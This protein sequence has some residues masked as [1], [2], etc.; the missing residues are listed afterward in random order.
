MRQVSIGQLDVS[1][2][3]CMIHDMEG[4]SSPG[5]RGVRDAD[6]LTFRQRQVL[7]IIR[8]HL[9]ARGVPPSRAELASEL[10]VAHPSGVASHLQALEKAGFIQTFPSIE[11]GIRLLREGA[12]LYE[13]AQELLE[14]DAP[15]TRRPALG[16]KPE[17]K[18]VDGFESLANLFEARP[19]LLLRMKDGG[20][21]EGGYGPSDI[22]VVAR[23]LEPR[24]GDMVVTRT[25]KEVRVQRYRSGRAR[26]ALR[27]VGVMV[28]RIVARRQGEQGTEK[29][30]ERVDTS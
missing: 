1:E 22:A 4:V 21:D 29:G 28:G 8:S 5:R 20:L 7:D 26:Q 11:R 9:K 19:A 24:D 12:P 14:L 16:T 18:R 25:D 3:T 30:K 10:N 17:P 27:L 13:D 2:Q 23:D 6:G 15:P